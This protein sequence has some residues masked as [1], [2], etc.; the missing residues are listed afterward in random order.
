VYRI[1]F[2]R[3]RSKPLL[4]IDVPVG[5]DVYKSEGPTTCFQAD[6]ANLN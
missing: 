4:A 2:D 6:G 3:G 5:A 1:N